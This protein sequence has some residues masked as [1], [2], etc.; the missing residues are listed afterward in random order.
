[1]IAIADDR[2]PMVT[3][4]RNG[5]FTMADAT[6]LLIACDN[7]LRR[8]EPFA[9]SLVYDDSSDSSERDAGA[10][11]APSLARAR[12]LQS[13]SSPRSP[14]SAARW[15]PS[16]TKR[17]ARRGWWGESRSRVGEKSKSSEEVWRHLWAARSPR[18]AHL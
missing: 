14:R 18:P 2:W 17:A 16:P 9:V 1:M 6:A 10:G 7:V 11:D 12:N 4:A 15:P 3:I 13:H 5:P 8:R